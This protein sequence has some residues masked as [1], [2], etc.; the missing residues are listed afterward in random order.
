MGNMGTGSAEAGWL[1]TYGDLASGTRGLP[2]QAASGVIKTVGIAV[3]S[4]TVG[5][6]DPRDYWAQVGKTAE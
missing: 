6:S 4:G 2:E 3:F 1:S 5:L